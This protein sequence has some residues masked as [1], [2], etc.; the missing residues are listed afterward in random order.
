LVIVNAREIF[1]D[2]TAQRHHAQPL[3]PFRRKGLD[4][5][6]DLQPPLLCPT[7]RRKGVSRCS[8]RV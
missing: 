6:V 1:A 8:S 4:R 2:R 7:S 3:R 5:I